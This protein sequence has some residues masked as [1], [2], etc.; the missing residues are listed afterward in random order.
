MTHPVRCEE[1]EKLRHT[2]APSGE[3]LL[4]FV[5]RIVH[6]KGLQV[7]IRA[8]PRILADYPEYA[9]AGRRQ[10]WQFVVALGL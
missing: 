10:K 2:Y 4:L 1:L 7:L 8:M 3:R 6:E 9:L 5:G